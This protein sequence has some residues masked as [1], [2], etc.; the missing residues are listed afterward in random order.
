MKDKIWSDQITA[1][2]HRKERKKRL[3][4]ERSIRLKINLIKAMQKSQKA[5]DAFIRAH[6]N[7]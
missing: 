1:K 6:C 7:K 5:A 2:H 4:Q 3:H